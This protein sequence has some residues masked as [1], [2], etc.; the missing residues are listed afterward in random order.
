MPGP[1]I[2]QAPRLGEHTRQ[3]CLEDLGMPEAEF[4]RLVAVGALEVWV[5]PAAG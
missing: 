1:L 3:I 5:P 2:T 4:D